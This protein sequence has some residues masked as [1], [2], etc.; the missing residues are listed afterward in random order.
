MTSAKKR[1]NTSRV[2]PQKHC[3]VNGFSMDYKC[4]SQHSSNTYSSGVN[5]RHNGRGTQ[6]RLK[7]SDCENERKEVSAV[8][9]VVIIL[10]IFRSGN[11]CWLKLCSATI[12]FLIPAWILS[13]LCAFL[14][15]GDIWITSF[16]YV[17]SL[18]HHVLCD[19]F[20][21]NAKEILHC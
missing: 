20:S 16:N 19:L 2:P 10:G 6:K 4:T 7:L 15:W 3:K 8:S 13:L 11:I 9:N 5:S 17:A 12:E 18:K 1:N 21:L 14:I